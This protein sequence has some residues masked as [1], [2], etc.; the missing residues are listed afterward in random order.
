MTRCMANALGKMREIVDSNTIIGAPITAGDGVTILPVSKISFGFV[1]GGTDF[2]TEKQRDLFG[3][4]ASSG[5]S[6]T[7]VG[8]LVIR[9][10]N[11]RLIQLAEGGQTI[12][13]VL[14]MVPEVMDKVEGL[15]NKAT[16]KEDKQPRNDAT[17]DNL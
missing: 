6:I 8:F 7:P 9:G 12:D 3:G 2:A 1:S 4:A 17:R 14:N 13:R 10:T 5:A 16:K 11:V 15:I